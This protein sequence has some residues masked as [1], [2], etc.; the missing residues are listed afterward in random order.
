MCLYYTH[1]PILIFVSI[2]IMDCSPL[3]S[4]SILVI[5]N[6][7]F[8]I[9]CSVNY[10]LCMIVLCIYNLN[11]L[12]LCNCHIYSDYLL[13]FVGYTVSIFH[14]YLHIV[15]IK[16]CIFLH[17]AGPTFCKISVIIPSI[18]SAF[19]FLKFSIIFLVSK[20]IGSLFS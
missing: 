18:P 8:C 4:E 7:F 1:M 10:S 12:F 6:Y 11:A 15:F 17:K 9:F 2:Y 13:L 3:H 19:W 16:P 5:T 14:G 20:Y